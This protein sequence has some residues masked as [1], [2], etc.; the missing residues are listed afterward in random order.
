MLQTS[1]IVYE[2]RHDE[3]PNLPGTNGVLAHMCDHLVS[4]RRRVGG[5]G[6]ANLAVASVVHAVEPLEK[7]EAI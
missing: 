1:A 4:L 7:C 6:Q 2:V 5:L 3:S